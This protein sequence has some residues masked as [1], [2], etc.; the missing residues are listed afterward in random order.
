MSYNSWMFEQRAHGI[1]ADAGERGE[2]QAEADLHREAIGD[3]DRAHG[4][5]AR[6]PDHPR[7]HAAV[8][9]RRPDADHDTRG[10]GG[11][12]AEAEPG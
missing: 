9:P 11:T 12:D 3:R 1:A 2:H 7:P 6:D 5:S 4:P 10:V 8:A